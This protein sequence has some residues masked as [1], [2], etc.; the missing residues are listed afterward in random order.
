MTTPVN[1][2]QHQ[3]IAGI[4]VQ[5]KFLQ[6]PTMT[7]SSNSRSGLRAEHHHEGLFDALPAIGGSSTGRG[8]GEDSPHGNILHLLICGGMNTVHN[9][10]RD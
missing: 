7:A 4:T 3:H 8:E 5:P 2:C 6:Q 1:S 10:S 9:T